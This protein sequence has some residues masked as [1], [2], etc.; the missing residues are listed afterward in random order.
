MHPTDKKKSLLLFLTVFCVYT[1]IY[2]TKNCFSAAMAAIVDAGVL[3][4]SQTGLI[5]AVFFAL[6]APLQIV[7]G[8]LA[9][10]RNPAHMIELGLLG[11]ALSNAVIFLF[12]HYG[13]MLAAW[14]F[15]AIVQTGV[16]PAVIKII[17]V[18]LAPSH[19]ERANFCIAFSTSL[20]LA[21]AYAV[22]A[23]LH[24]WRDNFLFCAIVLLVLA[25]VFPILNRYVRPSIDTHAPAGAKRLLTTPA[26]GIYRQSGLI[27]ILVYVVLRA[28]V[29]NGIKTLSATMLMETHATVSPSIGNRLGVLILLAGIVGT[30][31]VHRLKRFLGDEVT[32]TM[33]LLLLCLP[34]FVPLCLTN[35]IGVWGITAALCLITALLSG[36]HYLLMCCTLHYAPYGKSGAVAGLT[37]AAAALGIILQSVGSTSLAETG[38]WQM[39]SFSWL[40]FIA[41]C[42][43]L[44][45]PTR[46]LWKRFTQKESAL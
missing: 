4:K 20:G 31:V 34:F 40:A 41:L 43:L 23:F 17:S 28:T 10:R 26:K 11:G 1:L 37:N 3:T 2:M 35:S 29:E 36:T 24:H 45:I 9:D 42:V 44:I 8:L 5:N 39:V 25:V 19:R 7:G 46:P 27:L 14:S 15:N 16:W 22:A 12:P 21:F 6:Y 18:Q 32:G 13:V 38:G 30:L 33:W